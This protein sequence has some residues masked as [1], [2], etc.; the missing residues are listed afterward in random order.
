MSTIDK[1]RIAAVAT[2]KA[3]GYTFTPSTG[4]SLP[5]GAAPHYAP[6]CDAM[7]AILIHRADTLAGCAEGSPEAAELERIAGAIGAYEAKRWP[8]GKAATG[9][10]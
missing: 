9:K 8:E 2:L 1:E 5:T 3:L 10:G 6:E 7:H 4:W